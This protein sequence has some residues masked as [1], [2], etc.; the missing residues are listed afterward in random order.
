MEIDRRA[1]G[2]YCKREAV[3]RRVR[4]A[5]VMGEIARMAGLGF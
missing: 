5:D 1:W 4:Q 2:K 3:S